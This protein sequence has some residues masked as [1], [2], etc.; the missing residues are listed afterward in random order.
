MTH[1]DELIN[2]GVEYIKRGFSIIPVFNKKPM[3]DWK[4]YQEKSMSEFE[5]QTILQTCDPTGIAIITG[6]IS[7]LTVIDV[8]TEEANSKLKLPKTPT[9]K[10]SKGYHYYFRYTKELKTTTSKVKGV[11]IR[12]DGGY[13]VVPPSIHKSGHKYTW[14]VDLDNEIA[15]VPIEQF[16]TKKEKINNNEEVNSWETLFSGVREGQRNNTT[17]KIVG[18]LVSLIPENE[19]E[20]TVWPLV[21]AINKNNK[22]PLE[23]KE[24]RRT[25]E[26]ITK[27]SLESK[28][29][30]ENEIKIISIEDL[31][32]KIDK[33]D[34]FLIEKLLPS[35]LNV[36]SGQPG[37]GKSWIMLEIAK[38]VATGQKLFEKYESVQGSVLIIDGE[39]GE[40]ELKKRM[41]QMGFESSWPVFIISE[42]GIKIDNPETLKFIQSKAKELKIK[43]IILDPLSAMH[44]K[45]ENNAEDM[46]IVMESMA[47]LT[48]QGI[49]VLFLHHHRKE[50]GFG[51]SNMSQNLRGSSVILSRVD[52]QTVIINK[53]DEGTNTRISYSQEKMRNGKRE[54][55]FEIFLTEDDAGIYLKHAGETKVEET[56]ISKAINF[57]PTLLTESGKTKEEISQ[58]LRK[59]DIQVRTT[60][61][62][63]KKLE[64]SGLIQK[65]RKGKKNFYTIPVKP[66]F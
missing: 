34:R 50:N 31:F 43:L 9:V 25:F 29:P 60:S 48:N 39:S 13:V 7:N 59:N 44:T 55:P 22:P 41:K 4:Q 15:E 20:R 53:G 30:S 8:D 17:T 64:N 63:L 26:S 3:V 66:E 36:M 35:K 18:K 42:Q 56:K 47:S 38:S 10:T 5:F 49:T 28:K 11:D 51:N 54:K 58:I 65:T 52:S 37:A 19:W 27:L 62:A 1:K 24:L 2:V 12:S 23:T 45:T 32:N 14:L 61:S 33:Q 46:Q 6:K 40:Q 57:I 21:L 16:V